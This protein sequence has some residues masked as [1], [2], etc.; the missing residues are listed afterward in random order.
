[1]LKTRKKIVLANNNQLINLK[2]IFS[3]EKFFFDNVIN[4]NLIKIKV[5]IKQEIFL[6]FKNS[7]SINLTNVNKSLI[8]VLYSSLISY[9]INILKSIDIKPVF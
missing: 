7:H 2:K 3:K 1:M 6:F 4:M 5:L 9:D 8:N